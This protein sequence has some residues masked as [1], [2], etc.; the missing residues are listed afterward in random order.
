[1]KLT[2]AP[3]EGRVHRSSDAVAFCPVPIPELGDIVR[4][5]GKGS[6]FRLLAELIVSRSFAITPFV[7]LRLGDEPTLFLYGDLA[8]TVSGEQIDGRSTST[9]IE[10]PLTKT[11]SLEAG[12]TE[13]V[14]N[15]AD[16]DLS[17]GT[18]AADGFIL[19]PNDTI[20]PSPA[21]DVPASIPAAELAPADTPADV[22]AA[23]SDGPTPIG[24]FP[25]RDA[26]PSGLASAP[27]VEEAGSSTATGSHDL[28]PVPHAPAPID[29]TV[30]TID[31][32]DF[33]PFAEPDVVNLELIGSVAAPET[34]NEFVPFEPSLPSDP[35]SVVVDESDDRT[36]ASDATPPLDPPRGSAPPGLR[37][38]PSSIPRA[39]V[40]RDNIEPAAVPPPGGF[41]PPTPGTGVGQA[42]VA[43]ASPA[44]DH[45]DDRR[46]MLRVDDG[47]LHAVGSGLYVGRY[48][49]KKGLPDG[50]GEVV[51]QG[52]DISRVHWRITAEPTGALAVE[53]LGSTSGTSTV[54]PDGVA[55]RLDPGMRRI[56]GP[57]TKIV[58]GDRWAMLER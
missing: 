4:S 30:G 22:Q 28:P 13:R 21:S 57:G 36:I 58:F 34:A 40:H 1:M 48:P 10:R 37:A 35:E 51:V 14:S 19:A 31:D 11:F 39:A 33:D 18:V 25:A 43:D 3:G 42:P 46:A 52:E 45:V 47:Q 44:L 49:S 16:C 55:Q 23:S 7:V 50:Y 5:G 6:L 12:D 54:G 41:S 26:A 53:D 32:D 20:E 9:W 38:P 15:Y 2:V 29:N 27:E 17:A 56:I 8:V 24:L